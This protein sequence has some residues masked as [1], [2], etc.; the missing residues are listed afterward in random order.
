VRIFNISFTGRMDNVFLRDVL[1]VVLCGSLV[2]LNQNILYQPTSFRIKQYLVSY[3]FLFTNG[4]EEK[5]RTNWLCI[6]IN[7]RA[8]LKCL[9]VSLNDLILTCQQHVVVAGKNIVIGKIKLCV[10]S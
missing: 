8:R 3:L 7:V 5:N 10:V 4:F 2:S 1:I 9:T 6:F